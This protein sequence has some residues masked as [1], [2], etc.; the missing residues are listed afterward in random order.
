MNLLIYG[1]FSEKDIKDITAKRMASFG[2]T[3]ILGFALAMILVAFL[4][5]DLKFIYI[6]VLG[7]M[8]GLLCTF[9]VALMKM[10][11]VEGMEV[12]K[13]LKQPEKLFSTSSYFLVILASGNLLG[14][15]WVPYLMDILH[16]PDYLTVAMFL[17]G[18]SASVAASLFW[19]GRSFK[20]LRNSVFLDGAAPA[21]ALAVPIPLAHPAI[22]SLSSFMYTGANFIG[23]FLYARYNEWLGAIRSSILLVVILNLAQA[24]VAPVGILISDFFYIFI[25][26]IIIKVI[27]ISF[28]LFIIPEVAVIPE[29]TARTYSFMLYTNSSTGYRVSVELSKETI[30]TTLRLAGFF[31]VLLLVYIIYRTLFLMIF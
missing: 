24:L 21:L 18:T 25:I 15:I 30:M 27:A 28:V 29:E 7:A 19:K 3:S 5:P 1:S 12:P 13:G 26:V 22:F 11:H 6:Y 9:T 17:A 14:I 4:P 8:I 20:S 10:S 16:A 31:L 2:I 23:S